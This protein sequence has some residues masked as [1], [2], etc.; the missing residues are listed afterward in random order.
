MYVAISVL[1]R[2]HLSLTNVFADAEEIWNVE[3]IQVSK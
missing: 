3:P 1:F 2:R